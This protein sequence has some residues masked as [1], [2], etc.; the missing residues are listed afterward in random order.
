[1]FDRLPV[2][3]SQTYLQILNSF[4]LV[5]GFDL[6]KIH[7]NPYGYYFADTGFRTNP[8]NICK[9]IC[10][11]N[12]PFASTQGGRFAFLNFKIML[13]FSQS[14]KI[15][16]LTIRMKVDNCAAGP[17]DGGMCTCIS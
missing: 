2:Y 9:I 15:R 16:K 6:N 5:Y 11:E 3:K 12:E 10:S 17:Y 1:M 4:D 8:F 13:K 7:I 14:T